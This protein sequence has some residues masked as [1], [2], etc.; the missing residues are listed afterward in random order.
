MLSIGVLITILGCVACCIY[1]VLYIVLY[2][3]VI[4]PFSLLKDL[5]SAG[6]VF[7]PV[8]RLFSCN[9]LCTGFIY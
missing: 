9:Y 7:R 6:I 3:S 1:I 8:S 5:S 4:S 2:F